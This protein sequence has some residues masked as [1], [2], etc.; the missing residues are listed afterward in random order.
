[1]EPIIF[2]PAGITLFIFSI[3]MFGVSFNT[4]RRDWNE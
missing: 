2:T 3:I 4:I 1:M